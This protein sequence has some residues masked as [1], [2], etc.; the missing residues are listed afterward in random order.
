MKITLL[1]FA[2][3]WSPFKPLEVSGFPA[4]K[5]GESEASAIAPNPFAPCPRKV[6]RLRTAC[7]VWSSELM[8][9]AFILWSKLIEIHDRLSYR[10]PG[11]NFGGIEV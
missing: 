7:G 5:C 8:M 2:G 9:R 4:D 10:N 6:L 11:G 3:M 1:A